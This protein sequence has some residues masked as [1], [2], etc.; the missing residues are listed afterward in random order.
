LFTLLFGNEYGFENS[1]F[2]TLILLFLFYLINKFETLNPY[3]S[4]YRYKLNY[5]SDFALLKNENKK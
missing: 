1:I 3:I 2:C 4:S 5:S